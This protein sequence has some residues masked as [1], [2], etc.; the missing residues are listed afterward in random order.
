M[1]RRRHPKPI[2]IEWKRL[3]TAWGYAY[4]DERR[5]ELDPRMKPEKLM[6]IAIHEALHI[7][8]PDL[9][10]AAIDRAAKNVTD[11]LLRCGFWRKQT[12]DSW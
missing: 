2:M 10:E 8:I 11:V 4:P 1:P 9:D 3:T 7:Q 6:E 5:I 12:E